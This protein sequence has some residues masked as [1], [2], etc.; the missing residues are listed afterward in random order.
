MAAQTLANLTAL[1]CP[2]KVGIFPWVVT[3]RI[4]GCLWHPG[5]MTFRI[6]Q[7]MGHKRLDR[8][9]DH[10][11]RVVGVDRSRGQALYEVELRPRTVVSRW[12][13]HEIEPVPE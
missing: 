13:E 8:G 11:G 12:L 10:T 2:L 4:D 7:L 6:G 9:G 1:N 3:T 5:R